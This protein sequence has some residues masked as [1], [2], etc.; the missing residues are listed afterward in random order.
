[1]AELTRNTARWTVVD[2]DTGERVTAT[3]VGVTGIVHCI[4]GFSVSA[5]NQPDATLTVEVKSGSTV[6]DQYELPAELLAPVVVNYNYPIECGSGE[7]AIVTVG[8]P[9]AGVASAVSLRGFSIMGK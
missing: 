9:G 1:M 7:D 5:N 2:A 4:T 8:S 6:I 3:K